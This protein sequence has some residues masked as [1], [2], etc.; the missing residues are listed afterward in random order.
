MSSKERGEELPK[1][2]T[3]FSFDSVYIVGSVRRLPK[4]SE[5]ERQ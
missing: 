2:S 3:K 5:N 4:E 1:F